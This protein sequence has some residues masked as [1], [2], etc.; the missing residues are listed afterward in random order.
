MNIKIHMA[1]V[2]TSEFERFTWFEIEEF[3][4]IFTIFLFSFLDTLLS[5][6]LIALH[7]SLVER[8]WTCIKYYWIDTSIASIDISFSR[9][10][11]FFFY[12]D[13]VLF[14]YIGN[15]EVVV[16]T[17]SPFRW[18]RVR[19]IKSIHFSRPVSWTDRSD[20]KRKRKCT[21]MTM[22]FFGLHPDE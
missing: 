21:M 16:F 22:V 19:F 13:L 11:E 9:H 15:I 17:L 7:E 12:L 20:D 8:T 6:E 18:W 14:I 1:F 10:T 3:V 4:S 2:C 5:L